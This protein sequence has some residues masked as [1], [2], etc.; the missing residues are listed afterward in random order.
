[1]RR[2]LGAIFQVS[3]PAVIM[4]AD[5]RGEA[6]RISMRKRDI[7]KRGP[8]AAMN[9]KAQQAGKQITGQREERFAQSSPQ[10]TVVRRIFRFKSSSSQASGWG[11]VSRLPAL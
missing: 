11:M 10:S 1:M 3:V 2:T 7:A 6:R 8:S 5:W 9:S 4:R